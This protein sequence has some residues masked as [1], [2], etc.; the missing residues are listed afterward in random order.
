VHTIYEWPV[1]CHHAGSTCGWGG[2][3]VPSWPEVTL[4]VVL[5]AC[6]VVDLVLVPVVSPCPRGGPKDFGL[7]PSH[8]VV[9]LPLKTKKST[10]EINCFYRYIILY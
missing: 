3:R 1:S 10:V 8:P 9:P 2:C 7:L 6:A 5:W 4:Q